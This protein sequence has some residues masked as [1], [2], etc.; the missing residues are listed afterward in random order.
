MLISKRYN[1]VQQ[2]MFVLNFVVPLEILVYQ[3]F[4]YKGTKSTTSTTK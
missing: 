2:N 4:L 1:R 3:G